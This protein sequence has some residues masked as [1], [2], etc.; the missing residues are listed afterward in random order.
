M[1]IYIYLYVSICSYVC[2][3]MYYFFSIYLQM[4]LS[5]PHH[6][7]HYHQCLCTPSWHFSHPREAPCPIPNFAGNGSNCWTMKT[8]PVAWVAP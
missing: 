8:S 5:V 7:V 6:T 4:L 1:Y 3:H 2:T